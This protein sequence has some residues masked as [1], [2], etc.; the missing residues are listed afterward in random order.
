[1]A[2]GLAGALAAALAYG[3]ATVLQAIGV[4]RIEAGPPGSSFG[5]RLRLGYPFVVGLAL[6]G[7]GFASSLAALRSL[8]LFLVQSAVA[9]SVAVT[10][11][12]VVV[13]L[14]VRLLPRE[15]AALAAV[16]VG[17]VLLALSAVDGPARPGSDRLGWWILG[18]VVP[19]AA[20]VL[21]ADRRLSGGGRVVWLA[22]ASGLGYGMVG[23]AARVL[24]VGT[25]WWRTLAE[26]TLW[27]VV[28]NSAIGVL[29]YARALAHGRTTSVAAITV[30][31]ETL[32][33][34]AI[35][36][37][38][39][40]DAVRPHLGLVAGAGFLVTVVGCL[41]LSLRPELSPEATG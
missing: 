22:L 8:P 23:V 26:P 36:L 19:L 28:G 39:L 3:T 41:V 18:L 5:T 10:A 21:V 17:L 31:A 20:V 6:D 33:P 15:V 27:A 34:A 13:V 30:A 24:V 38:F 40:G 29:A 12:L 16:A 2:W 4:R 9:S 11:V 25:P 14:H 7:A 37:V 35:G 32:V 1:M